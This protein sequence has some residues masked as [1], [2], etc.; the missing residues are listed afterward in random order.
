MALDKAIQHG[1]EHRKE[2]R[3]AQAV[4]KTCR[5]HGSC[6]YC[7]KNRMYQA[8]KENEKA[9]DKERDFENENN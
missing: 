3:H 2:Y 7:L 9:K 5:N 4:D 8:N 6:P 1:K